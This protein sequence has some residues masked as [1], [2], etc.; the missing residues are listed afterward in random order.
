MN[1]NLNVAHPCSVLCLTFL[2]QIGVWECCF[3]LR[4]RENWSTQQKPLR[5]KERTNT[6]LNPQMALTPDHMGGGECFH[7]CATLQVQ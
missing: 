1:N 2:S 5:V 4:R 7:H 3:I 6:K